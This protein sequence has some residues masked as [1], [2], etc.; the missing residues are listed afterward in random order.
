VIVY[1]FSFDHAKTMVVFSRADQT[2][3]AKLFGRDESAIAHTKLRAVAITYFPKPG[4]VRDPFDNYMIG[5][6]FEWFF[7][8][9]WRYPALLDLWSTPPPVNMAINL[10]YVRG[11]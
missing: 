1:A 9:S 10:V 2:G 6:I 8:G 7:S 4:Q 11:I 3:S 5:S